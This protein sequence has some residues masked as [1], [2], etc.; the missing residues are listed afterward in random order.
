MTQLSES[1]R[2]VALYHASESLD[3]G[4]VTV[5]T[6]EVYIPVW[7][8]RNG[9]AATVADAQPLT[10]A[11]YSD[12]QGASRL[13]RQAPLT[14]EGAHGTTIWADMYAA[15]MYLACRAGGKLTW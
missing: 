2:N 1:T 6:A 8:E 15:H 14:G 9:V 7:L 5:P 10:G 13:V 4:G 11:Y 12:F 3:A